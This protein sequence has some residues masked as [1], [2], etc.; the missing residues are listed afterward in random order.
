MSPQHS[1]R[2]SLIEGTLRCLAR[3]PLER[4][5]ARAIADE[6]GANLASIGYHF[7][8]KDRLIAE[9]VVTGLDQWLAELIETLDDLPAGDR[10]AAAAAQFARTRRAHTGL[11]RTLVAAL[12]LAPHDEQIRATLTTGY[13]RARE[14]IAAQ[15]D[16]TTEAA[17]LLLAMFQGLLFQEMVSDSLA[18]EGDQLRD[19][20]S[21]VAAALGPADRK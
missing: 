9:S 5:T 1:N 6:S 20:L 14:A 4:V 19:A 3:L 2:S 10:V 7:G 18:V 8:S 16:S 11:V 15:L 21:G 12:A 17:G 13:T